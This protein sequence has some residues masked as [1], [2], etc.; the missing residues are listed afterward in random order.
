[1]STDRIRHA[2]RW[3]QVSGVWANPRDP[4]T[5]GR[6]DGIALEGGV[7]SYTITGLTNG[8]ATGVFVRSFTGGSYSER[9]GHSSEWVRIKGEHTTPVAVE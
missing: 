2:L 9:S 3:S 5:G 6:E 8:A 7:A 4:R 1:V